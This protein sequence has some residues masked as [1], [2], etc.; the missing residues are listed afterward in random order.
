[1]FNTIQRSLWFRLLFRGEPLPKITIAQ[2]FMSHK[3]DRDIT[4]YTNGSAILWD[5]QGQV[6]AHY[7]PQKFGYIYNVDFVEKCDRILLETTTGIFLLNQNGNKL[8]HLKHHRAPFNGI[9]I[10]QNFPFILTL[11]ST[12]C[13]GENAL[14]ICDY[15]GKQKRKLGTLHGTIQTIEISADYQSISTISDQN[16]T[17]QWHLYPIPRSNKK[18]CACQCCSS[19]NPVKPILDKLK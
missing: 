3:G 10:Q 15:N 14:W 18:T 5:L 7:L 11:V 9:P 13:P 19:Q 17:T 16:R 6:I 2:T 8:A 4:V 12:K 1:M